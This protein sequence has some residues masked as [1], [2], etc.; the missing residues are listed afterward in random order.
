MIKE[1]RKLIDRTMKQVE[2]KGIMKAEKTLVMVEDATSLKKFMASPE[3][4]ELFTQNRHMNLAIIVNAH[5]YKSVINTA[6]LNASQI[7]I[8]KCNNT[9]KEA[10][11][12]DYAPN[13]KKDFMKNMAIAFEPDERNSHPFFMINNKSQ[14]KFR[15]TLD[16]SM[17]QFF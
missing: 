10:L 2:Q 16:L 14:N 12:D 4:T 11:A 15:K 13:R 7:A 5:K 6:R 1:A 17:S 3:F 8:F 9:E